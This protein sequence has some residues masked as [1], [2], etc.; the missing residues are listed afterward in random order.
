MWRRRK[1]LADGEEEESWYP[2]PSNPLNRLTKAQWDA[3]SKSSR[4]EEEEAGYGDGD[5]ADKV[6]ALI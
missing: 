5:E 4:S 1:G 6:M 3:L 2:D